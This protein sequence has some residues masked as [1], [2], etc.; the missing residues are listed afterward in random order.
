MSSQPSHSSASQIQ[1]IQQPQQ[2]EQQQ[3][4][5]Q[6]FA[7][8]PQ[9]RRR[10]KPRFSPAY[11]NA[12]LI[13][14][15]KPL[16]AKQRAMRRER[17]YHGTLD[18]AEELESGEFRLQFGVVSAN[19]FASNADWAKR[20]ASNE[21]DLIKYLAA[22]PLFLIQIDIDAATIAEL[23]GRRGADLEGGVRPLREAPDR[24]LLSLER[25]WVTIET[26]RSGARGAL[27]FHNLFEAPS[28]ARVLSIRTSS[29]A[30][31]T[32]LN[33]LD[34]LRRISDA[35]LNQIKREL[36]RA[37]AVG[38]LTVFD[39]GQGE[40]IGMTG[41]G[42]VGCYF[43]FGGGVASNRKTFP[44]RLKQ[45]CLCNQP[46]IILSHWDH[47][48]WSSEGRDTR[49][50]ARTWI[51]PRQSAK[52]SKRAP[53]HSAL[54]GSIR[55]SRGTI[56]IWPRKVAAKKFG[57]IVVQQCSGSSKNSSGLALSLLPPK[58][59]SGKPVLL[60][61]DAG[62]GDLP[63]YPK[64]GD[65]DAIVCPH[66]GGRSNSPTVPRPP[67]RSYRRLFYTYGKGNSYGHPLPKTYQ[68]H[69]TAKWTDKR[70]KR[71]P[72]DQLA[73][74]TADRNRLGL[75]HVGFD[76]TT[77]RSLAKMLCSVKRSLDVQQK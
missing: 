9:Q 26:G 42:H 32:S 28:S 36:P 8:H 71:P 47:D 39:V 12:F 38:A 49:V 33:A 35:T 54:I 58:R 60:P 2:P 53:H 65:L 24:A 34:P 74:N 52:S 57:Q 1:S 22:I 25:R 69:H 14:Q 75:G 18:Q 4:Q 44:T 50:H 77:S 48:H 6:Q 72:P 20:A 21:Q 45:F 19:W 13:K 29:L 67:G 3:Q 64:S 27:V 68:N 66:H 11:C 7:Q 62:Y 59:V 31:R 17:L 41:G 23:A 10:R 55:A 61:A 37:G 5:Q 56:L 15:E 51:V 70:V 43:D 46:P 73:R 16:S 40:A 76:W 63:R 30:T